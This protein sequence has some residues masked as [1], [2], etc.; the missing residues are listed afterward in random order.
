MEHRKLIETQMERFKAC[1]KEMKTK[2]FSKEGLSAQQKLDPKEVAKMEMS[3]WVSTMVDELGQQIERTEAEVE[4]L[5]SQTKKKKPTSGSDGR[6]SEL[7]AL[8]DRR[9]WHIGKLELIMRLLENGQISP[10][11]V[12]E[13][14]DDI[15]Y[16][17]ESNVEEDFTE[18][19]DLYESLN[20]QEEEEH[21]GLHDDLL[22]SHDTSSI[23]EDSNLSEEPIKEKMTISGAQIL[24]GPSVRKPTME[25]GTVRPAIVSGRTGVVTGM[26]L[27]TGTAPRTAPA[28]LPSLR[29]AS[30]AAAAASSTTA[31]TPSNP[32]SA[33]S[34][35]QIPAVPQPVSTS[36]H[37][38][39]AAVASPD[40]KLDALPGSGGPR[41]NLSGSDP[42]T[43]QEQS[44]NGGSSSSLV[45]NPSG[46]SNQSGNS[47]IGQSP[48]QGVDVDGIP[49]SGE[50]KLTAPTSQSNDRQSMGGEEKQQQEEE[51]RLD[52]NNQEN[53]NKSVSSL[54][55]LVETYD[56]LKSHTPSM[57]EMTKIIETGIS[58]LP[59]IQDAEKPYYYAPR[60]PYPT[61]SHYP[62][63]PMAFE[64]RPL[65]WNDIEV[66]I[67]SC[68][69]IE[70]TCLEI[71]KYYLTWFQRAKNPEEMADDYEKGSYTYFDWEADWLLR[72]KTPFQFDYKHLE[73]SL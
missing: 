22:S 57:N 33:K 19:D 16:Y 20:L 53:N 56:Q 50:Q 46:Q 37:R 69:R 15:Q 67:S 28:P 36:S 7:E 32:T 60:N 6:T 65:V 62:Q 58:G 41:T 11:R 26:V 10:E 48:P 47:K 61:S 38:P 42:S 30:A 68:K 39:F 12:G 64:K 25:S 73:D 3:H 45:H 18:D 40:T 71:H 35:G 8:N 52:F 5:R 21:Y 4:L 59:Q 51:N 66:E 23:I 31:T 14:K 43:S 49:N 63:H 34:P 17:V 27:P 29:Y 2:A 9:R 72:T 55:D 24:R 44:A 13:V 1:E 54:A 70:E